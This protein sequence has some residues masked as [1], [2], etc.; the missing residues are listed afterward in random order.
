M[1]I[2]YDV[3]II[4]SG[5]AGMAAAVY[6]SRAGLNTA[7]LEYSAPG[8]KLVKTNEIENYPGIGK[9]NGADLAM[10]MHEH[11]ISFGAKYLYG[12]VV[13]II[14]GKVKTIVCADGNKYETKSVIIATG[15]K[16]RK[17]NIPN[18]EEMIGR[19][20]SYCAVCDGAFFKDKVVT[21]IGGGNA[22]LEEALY[23]T[24][25]AN[26][27]YVVIRRD[28]FRAEKSVQDKVLDNDKI[29]VITKHLP[30]EIVTEGGFVSG[31]IIKDV[32]S[33]KKT[34]LDT[35]GIFPYIGSD[36]ALGFVNN[37]N[38]DLENGYV[39]VDNQMRTNVEGIYAAGDICVKQLRQV[40]TAANDGAIAAQAIFHDLMK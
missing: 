25:F 31:L 29:E 9:I 18:E 10:Q 34:K 24:N 37:L 6:A 36:P 11:S 3:I 7:I 17:L 22:A 4:G 21:V 28:E 39:V 1:D 30:V 32:E 40:V 20:V 13:D 2:Q 8:G 16:E 33:S 14:D 26:K 27:V 38:L 5:P 19:G 12:E 15:T 23:L 35:Q